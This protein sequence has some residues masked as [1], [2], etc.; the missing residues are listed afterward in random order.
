[1]SDDDVVR[2]PVER[3]V[4][5]AARP[6]VQVGLHLDPCGYICIGGVRV[7]RYIRERRCLQFYDKN[8]QRSRNRGTRFVEISIDELANLDESTNH[9]DVDTPE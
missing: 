4:P 3:L 7:A 9:K 6:P 5:E 8:R 1:M 2:R